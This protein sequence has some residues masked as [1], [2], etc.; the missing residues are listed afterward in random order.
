[1]CVWGGGGDRTFLSYGQ[2]CGVC[3]CVVGGGGGGPMVRF[4]VCVCV[5]GGI[6]LFCPMVRF[7]HEEFNLV[8]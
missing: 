6:V 3:V 5:G 2:I 4:A 8:P 1:M 7:S